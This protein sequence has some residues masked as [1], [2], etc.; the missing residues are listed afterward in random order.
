MA[1]GDEAL[2]PRLQMAGASPLAGLWRR[3]RARNAA[4]T[5]ANGTDTPTT[6][7]PPL[8]RR[9]PPLS[10][11]ISCGVIWMA[12]ALG[13]RRRVI[14]IAGVLLLFSFLFCY[15]SLLSPIMPSLS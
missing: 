7:G 4:I 6:A 10:T 12:A 2:A 15:C 3:P 13:S 1:G 8:L 9:L 14:V 5:D 11:A